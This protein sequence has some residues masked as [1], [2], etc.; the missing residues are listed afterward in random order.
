MFEK[1]LEVLFNPDV[2][3]STKPFGAYAYHGWWITPTDQKLEA[4]GKKEHWMVVKEHPGYFDL[5]AK[6]PIF[7]TERTH[8]FTQMAIDAGAIRVA[9]TPGAYYV[10]STRIDKSTIDRLWLQFSDFDKKELMWDCKVPFRGRTFWRGKLDE[11]ESLVECKVEESHSHD[12]CMECDA[13]PTREVRWANGRGHAWFCDTCFNEWK[14]EHRGDIQSIKPIKDGKAAKKYS[15]NTNPT[16]KEAKTDRQLFEQ[17]RGLNE[18]DLFPSATPES[19]VQRAKE[20]FKAEMEEKFSKVQITKNSDNTV[21]IVGDIDFSYHRG[22]SLL[23]LPYKIRKVVGGFQVGQCQL[24]SLEGS[25]TQVDDSKKSGWQSRGFNCSTNHLTTLVGGPQVV[26]SE[27]NC[28]DNP[29]TSLHG[30][31]SR[32]QNFSCKNTSITSLEGLPEV[33]GGHLD[34]SGNKNLVSLKGLSRVIKGGLSLQHCPNLKD[35]SELNNTTVYGNVTVSSSSGLDLRKLDWRKL[36]LRKGIQLVESTT[37]QIVEKFE[38]DV[39]RFLRSAQGLAGRNGMDRLGLQ[40]DQITDNDV[41]VF[42][43]PLAIIKDIQKGKYEGYKLFWI[44]TTMNDVKQKKMYTPGKDRGGRRRSQFSDFNL[45]HVLAISDGKEI[46]YSSSNNFKQI[47]SLNTIATLTDIIV[48]IPKAKFTNTDITRQRADSQEG[49]V[50]PIQ[51]YRGFSGKTRS[52]YYRKPSDD[53]RARYDKSVSDENKKRYAEFLHN[54]HA[55][56]DFKQLVRAFATDLQKL[57]LDLAIGDVESLSDYKIYGGETYEKWDNRK[58]ELVSKMLE[59]LFSKIASYNG[60]SRSAED[61]EEEDKQYY[62]KQMASI[63][64]EIYGTYNFFKEKKLNADFKSY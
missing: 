1:L 46:N 64:Q 58:K 41:T 48:A 19:L 24:T 44:I 26:N 56:I 57:L 40:L 47:S 51:N 22:F 25:P 18:E 33:L 35:F 29:L 14:E 2:E 4:F 37:G 6:D 27:Y 16:I 53:A 43:D 62:I 20:R 23:A 5:D 50:G 10:D 21:D 36:R 55:S 39:L 38:S 3:T 49:A 52:K 34:A 32:C 42:E 11:L 12:K 9:K 8:K 60:A 45:P 7:K 31:P 63:K 59:N 28:S 13:K 54:R 61:K 17:L 30:A 15:E